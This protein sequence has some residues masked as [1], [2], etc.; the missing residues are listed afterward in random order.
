M[1]VPLHP[2]PAAHD[3]HSKKVTSQKS[4]SSPEH[5]S[6]IGARFHCFED[7]ARLNQKP[8]GS[9]VTDTALVISVNTTTV[10]VSG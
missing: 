5:Q 7:H 6:G 8:L 10:S 2:A 9:V 1:I 4:L 3:E